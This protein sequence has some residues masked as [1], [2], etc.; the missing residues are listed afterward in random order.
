MSSLPQNRL[1]RS[2][3]S[4]FFKE[5]SLNSL[6]SVPLLEILHFLLASIFSNRSSY[7]F[8]QEFED[9]PFSQK[10]FHNRLANPKVNW[11]RILLMISN[12]LIRKLTPLTSDTRKN[13]FI[14]DDSIYPRGRSKKVELLSK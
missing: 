12:N 9:K 10:T 2:S 8:L 14:V 3:I 4:T 1:I 11:R 5:I 6:V 13:V 7:Q